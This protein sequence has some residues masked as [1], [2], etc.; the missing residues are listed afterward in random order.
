MRMK[1]GERRKKKHS[2]L[3]VA[4]W[5]RLRRNAEDGGNEKGTRQTQ[6]FKIKL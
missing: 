3:A 2:S 6:K 5:V 4:E 1:K